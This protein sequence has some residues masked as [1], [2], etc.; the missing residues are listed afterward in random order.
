MDFII[1]NSKHHQSP[2]KFIFVLTSPRVRNKNRLQ[3]LFC[4]SFI[5]SFDF[6][7]V[8]GKI[9]IVQVDWNEILSFSVSCGLFFFLS[10]SFFKSI[11][12][13]IIDIFCS[14]PLH[15]ICMSWATYY[16]FAFWNPIDS[17]SSERK[18]CFVIFV[19]GRFKFV[20]AFDF[21]FVYSFISVSICWCHFSFIDKVFRMIGR[22]LIVSYWFSFQWKNKIH[23]INKQLIHGQSFSIDN[24]IFTLSVLLAAPNNPFK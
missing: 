20:C 11:N 24:P 13:R 1:W 22:T 23:D 8:T 21:V 5:C 16:L 3:F 19:W 18:K 15:C 4:Y 10:Y 14:L 2:H 12:N 17:I 9:I 7:C 6:I